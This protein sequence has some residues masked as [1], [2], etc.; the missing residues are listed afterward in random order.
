L[1]TLQEMLESSAGGEAS[2]AGKDGDGEDG[3]GEDDDN[4][5]AAH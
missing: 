3:D 5:V 1:L 2:N 4:E